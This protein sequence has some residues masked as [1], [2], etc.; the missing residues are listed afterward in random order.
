MQTTYTYIFIMSPFK[1]H[2]RKLKPLD[3][4]SL[5]KTYEPTADDIEHGYNPFRI[6]QLQNYNPM[7]NC[8][9]TLNDA[10]YNTIGLNHKYHFTTMDQL[11]DYETKEHHDSPVFIKYAPLLDPIR[12]MIGKYKNESSL[13][14]N[15]PTLSTDCASHPKM[16]DKNNAS[17]ID[18][19]F[20]FLSSQLLNTHGFVN[21]IDYYGSFLG[22]Q[23]KYKLNIADDLEYLHTSTYFAN[24]NNKLFKVSKLEDN[25]FFNFGSRS[26]KQ[27]LRISETQHNITVS[28]LIEVLDNGENTIDQCTD[29][30]YEKANV[31]QHNSTSSSSSS[32]DDSAHDDDSASDSE[33]DNESES[34]SDENDSENSE[35]S[36]SSESGSDKSDE[37]QEDGEQDQ[38]D[39]DDDGW[40]TD[41]ESSHFDDEEFVYAYINEFPVQLICLEK[42][43][44]TLDDLFVKEKLNRYEAASCL[45]Q[46][47]MTLI[48]YQKCFHFTH[49]DLHTNNI[50][51]KE[52]DIEYLIYKF[53]NKT[54]KVPTYGKIYKIIDFGRSIYRFNKQLLCSD[55]FAPGGDA[56]TQYNCEPFFNENHARL[57]PNYSF[58]LSRL[59]CSIYDFIIDEDDIQDEFDDLQKTIFR[60]CLDDHDKNILYKKNGEERYPNF[61]LYK[62]IARTVHKHTP[63]EQLKFAY[64][65]QFEIKASKVKASDNV[66]D[67]DA[68]PTYV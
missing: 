48:T 51:Y 57:E 5:E 49:N 62:M 23:E 28:S 68:L 26:N 22:V 20:S 61:K 42:C 45:F 12:F 47:I 3:L 56:A 13:I 67:I 19:F 37:D 38:E 4:E 31:V 25:E 15:L 55:S 52:T 29:L 65:K 17:Y 64:F 43:D 46:I 33:E 18:N 60:W 44:G 10:T 27:K 14:Q 59:G 2:Y 39:G 16:M 35:V 53:E 58:D 11:Y 6:Q 41:S 63:Q 40:E 34:G 7:Y 1:L 24:Q 30:V 36:N 50:M 54:Y 66:L 32:D 9:F 21:G 8:F